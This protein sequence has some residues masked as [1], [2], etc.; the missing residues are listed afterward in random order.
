MIR[1]HSLALAGIAVLVLVPAVHAFQGVTP[2]PEDAFTALSNHVGGIQWDVI[3]MG[4]RIDALVYRID[5]RQD[6]LAARVTALETTIAA[7][8]AIPSSHT[9]NGAINV[10]DSSGAMDISVT[11]P[12]SLGPDTC[13][14]GGGTTSTREPTSGF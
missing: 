13:T 4:K 1:S 14:V 2:T 3:D 11:P 12:E 10:Y 7:Q 8:T 5:D 9:I 6:D